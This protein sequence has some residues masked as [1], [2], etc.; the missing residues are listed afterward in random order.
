[1]D[2]MIPSQYVDA[3]ADLSLVPSSLKT[4]LSEFGVETVDVKA[5]IVLHIQGSFLAQLFSNIGYIINM[6]VNT[7]MDTVAILLGTINVT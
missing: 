3:Y 4:A 7:I 2:G 5:R 6:Y 1:M